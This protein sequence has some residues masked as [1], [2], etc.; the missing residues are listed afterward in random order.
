M[1]PINCDSNLSIS[2]LTNVQ[3]RDT[4]TNLDHTIFIRAAILRISYFDT[5]RVNALRC[6]HLL[7]IVAIILELHAFRRRYLIAILI[8]LRVRNIAFGQNNH[9]CLLR[10]IGSLGNRDAMIRIAFLFQQLNSSLHLLFADIKLEINAFA[11]IQISM[12]FNLIFQ[13]IGQDRCAITANLKF[14]FEIVSDSRLG[15]VKLFGDCGLGISGI[16]KSLN[17]TDHVFL[18]FIHRK[19]VHSSI[20]AGTHIKSLSDLFIGETLLL[21]ISCSL[22][23]VFVPLWI[24]T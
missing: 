3:V 11:N 5:I 22:K 16:V 24:L 17:T 18:L 19:R 2:T 9:V 10:R 4:F 21:Q 1:S 7:D 6:L 23:K 13:F 8:N 12:L 20:L 14:R 15:N